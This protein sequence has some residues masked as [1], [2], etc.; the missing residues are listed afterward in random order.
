MWKE[1]LDLHAKAQGQVF[2]NKKSLLALQLQ[3][4]AFRS[5]RVNVI[6]HEV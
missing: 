5:I 1:H 2:Q 6:S 4:V 3:D